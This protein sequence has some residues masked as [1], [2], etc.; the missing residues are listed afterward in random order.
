MRIVI[1]GGTFDPPHI[2]HAS[3][4]EAVTRLVPCD[5]VWVMIAKE[6]KDKQPRVSTKHRVEMTRRLLNEMFDDCPIPVKV[7]T[8]ELNRPRLKYTYDTFRALER[9]CPDHKFYFAISSELLRDMTATWKRGVEL[10]NNARFIVS[11]RPGVAL[12]MPLPPMALVV[13]TNYAYVDLS[14]T[15]IRG[16]IGRGLSGKPYLTPSVA[17]YVK[18]HGLYQKT[19]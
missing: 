18:E 17:A 11:H 14:S 8:F 16:L 13:G 2:G 4:I 10:F 7:S 6:R 3:V 9:E 1:Y 5:E 15:F 12:D 19:E